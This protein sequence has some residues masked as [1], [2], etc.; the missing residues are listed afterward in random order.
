MKN[1]VLW[2]YDT[3]PSFADHLPPALLYLGL[4]VVIVFVAVVA[5]AFTGFALWWAIAGLVGRFVFAPA[6]GL[7]IGCLGFVTRLVAGNQRFSDPV[8]PVIRRVVIVDDLRQ[9]N[10]AD[11]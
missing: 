2:L 7:A 9:S 4:W 6:M 11:A 8:H 5:I 3:F 10:E 1:L